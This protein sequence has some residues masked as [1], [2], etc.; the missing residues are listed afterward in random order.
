MDTLAGGQSWICQALA[1]R[2]ILPPEALEGFF[3]EPSQHPVTQEGSAAAELFRKIPSFTSFLLLLQ[4][5]F[6]SS[7]G[8][9]Q[10]E[11]RSVSCPPPCG[12]FMVPWLQGRGKMLEPKRWVFV[13]HLL[14]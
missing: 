11:G 5:C 12:V 3:F 6:D 9:W 2:E 4:E 13:F 10:H 1:A 14:S 7:P 8:V